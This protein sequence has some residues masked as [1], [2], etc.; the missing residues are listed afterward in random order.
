MK[1]VIE[2]T[3]KVSCLL[4]D[5]WRCL[6]KR[7]LHDCQLVL[8]TF[9]DG[10]QRLFTRP[11]LRENVLRV[12]EDSVKTLSAW[13]LVLLPIGEGP[14]KDIGG[15]LELVRYRD[16]LLEK[17]ASRI[18]QP[19]VS[20]KVR[21]E[22]ADIDARLESL[23]ATVFKD[24]REVLSMKTKLERMKIALKKYQSD[25]NWQCLMDDNSVML[26]QSWAGDGPQCEHIEDPWYFANEALKED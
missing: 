5:L 7:E 24:F 13:Q 12:D 17:L 8:V 18:H 15:L 26:Q 3:F 25:S 1:A 21:A 11:Q 2:G 6:G 14:E 4:K 20:K 23:P 9:I 19:D 22:L 16:T 10:K